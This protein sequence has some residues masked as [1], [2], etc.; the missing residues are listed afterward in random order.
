[1]GVL[2]FYNLCA[3]ANVNRWRLVC[4]LVVSLKI[5]SCGQGFSWFPFCLA[6][7]LP[8]L[9]RVYTLEL[10]PEFIPEFTP[11]LELIKLIIRRLFMN[12]TN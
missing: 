4:I 7:F 11:S 3:V 12:T 2:Q 5:P 10:T 9:P 6:S 1:M 8:S